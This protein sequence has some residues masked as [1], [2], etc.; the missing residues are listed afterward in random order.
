MSTDRWSARGHL[1]RL[2]IEHETLSRADV[3]TISYTLHGW[4]IAPTT[5]AG[6]P[7][8]VARV[9]LLASLNTRGHYVAPQR[10]AHLTELEDG[11]DLVDSVILMAIIQR[12]FLASRGPAWDDTA[13]A[14]QLGL[15]RDH[16]ERAQGVLDYVATLPLRQPRPAPLGTYWWHSA[17]T[18]EG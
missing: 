9:W 5:A 18:C 4:H 3:L 11:G 14:A 10:P 7:P 6:D 8:I 16:I 12:H 2:G 13:L 15:P 17:D 1:E